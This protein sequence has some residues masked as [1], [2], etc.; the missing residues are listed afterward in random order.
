MTGWILIIG[1]IVTVAA[2]AVAWQVVLPQVTTKLQFVGSAA[3]A[4]TYSTPNG[5]K[6]ALILGAILVIFATIINMLGVKVM[7]RINNFGV[8]AELIGR[9]S[10]SSCSSSTSAAVR[11]S[12]STRSAPAPGTPGATSAPS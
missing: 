11:A 6:N 10:W 1:S 5:A 7:A 9:R 2:V 8:I 3:D 4:G 12:S